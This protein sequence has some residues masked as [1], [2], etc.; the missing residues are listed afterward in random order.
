MPN[1]SQTMIASIA[2]ATADAVAV[3]IRP[4]RRARLASTVATF[5][6][7]MIDGIGSPTAR[8]SG[9]GTSLCHDRFISKP[10]FESRFGLLWVLMITAAE[11]IIRVKGRHNP[12]CRLGKPI[13]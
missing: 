7:R 10:A 12:S 8:W 5:V 6:G 9:I 3:D 13:P 1:I 4:R 11:S 2:R